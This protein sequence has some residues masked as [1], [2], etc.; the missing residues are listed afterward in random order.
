MF[1]GPYRSIIHSSSTPPAE[2]R[3][4]S[5]NMCITL[6]LALIA[7]C[8]SGDIATADEPA[9]MALLQPQWTTLE[10]LTPKFLSDATAEARQQFAQIIFDNSLTIAQIRE[11]LNEWAA[12]Q[13][14]EI[15]SEFEAAQM[16]MKSGLEQVSKAIPQSSLS[17]AA[18]EAFAK[19]QE[20]V[21]DMDQTA[22]QQREQIMSYIDSLPQ[23]VR[24]EMNGYIQS[25]VKDAVVAIKAKI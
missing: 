16:E 1:M 24:S 25:V 17:D 10:L 23:E 7:T 14:P 20:M 22:G 8:V 13:G 18:K 6:L 19:L 11:K 4:F 3:A 2:S 21:A 5:S 12:Q 9:T 15:Q